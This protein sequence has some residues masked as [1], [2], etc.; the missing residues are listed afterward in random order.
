MADEEN[1]G[2]E[3]TEAPTQRRRE[4]AREEGRVARSVE[5]S[6]AA[7]MLGGAILLSS[8]GV[9]GLSSFA[10]RT[11][12]GSAEWLSA[13]PISMATG[14]SILRTVAGGFVLAVLPFLLAL[15]AVILFVNL[16]QTRGVVSW[17]SVTPKWSNVDPIQ[18]FKRLASGEALFNLAKSVVKL[19]ILGLVTYTVLARSWP[20][21]MNLIDTSPSD[22]G[23]VIRTLLV[24]LAV[25]TGLAFFVVAAIDYA[26][27]WYKLEK[28]LRMTRQEVLLESRESE[29]DPM[30]KGRIR[31]MAQALA[32]RRMIQ[33]VPRADVVI[34]NPTEIAI[35][36]KYDTDVA[37]A[38]IVVAMGRR[39]LAERIKAVA[40]AS[41]VP[42]LEN[43]PV[44]R[45]LLAT[46]VVGKPIPPALYAAVAE[47]LAYVYRNRP[48]LA[49]T[50][51]AVSDIALATGR[52][53]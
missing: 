28:S 31:A 45:A 39:K 38:P 34:V 49:G 37:P 11:V 17:K 23:S 12:R 29:G 50:V 48:S 7:V 1:N 16:L 36:L 3:R 47:I 4:E 44:A 40:L 19:A 26:F 27:Q 9:R 6:A 25:M 46:A 15:T 13:G 2:Q 43:K 10:T 18:G 35:A 21:L 24:R 32:R 22:I 14:V 30:I 52:T 33:D 20:E 8:I 41:R 5:L 53:A 51:T 42:V